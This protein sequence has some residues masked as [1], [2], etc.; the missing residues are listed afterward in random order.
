MGKE[1]GLNLY[2][3]L[4]RFR[5][6]QGNINDH[7]FRTSL[8]ELQQFTKINQKKRLT[9]KQIINLL[10][11]M[12]DA[13]IIKI[14]TSQIESMNG[15]EML[16]IE[17]TD[18]V[19]T[20]RID[21]KDVIIDDEYYIP[22]NFYDIDFLYNKL[23]FNSRELAFYILLSM[24]GKRK[25]NKI[26]M[27]ID[28]MKNALGTRNEKITELLIKFN[29]VGIIYTLVKKEGYKEKFE[30]YMCEKLEKHTKF[31]R[32]SEKYRVAFLNRYVENDEKV[33]K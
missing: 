2:L 31:K 28:T 3:Q 9:V 29:E 10:L 16:L 5:I 33:N 30:H 20:D 17:A 13:K 21:D 11:K 12:Q 26:N 22:I 4:F 15:N 18:T 32:E 27:K 19:K 25:N 7:I 14:H 6:H 23:K 1:E 8:L 24:Y